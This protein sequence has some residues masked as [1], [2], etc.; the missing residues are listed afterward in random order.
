[1]NYHGKEEMPVNEE[2][3][4]MLIILLGLLMSLA[5]V[6]TVTVVTQ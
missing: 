2:T 1:M 4:G 5:I 3:K 6:S